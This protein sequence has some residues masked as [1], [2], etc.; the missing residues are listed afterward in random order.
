MRERRLHPAADDPLEATTAMHIRR[1]AFTLIE[2]LAVS[3]ARIAH[4]DSGGGRVR[5]RATSLER[6]TQ[7]GVILIAE[8]DLAPRVPGG[9]DPDIPDLHERHGFGSGYS[10]LTSLRVRW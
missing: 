6:C 5:D 2:L 4:C 10:L 7:N 3:I 8:A 1:F 9:N